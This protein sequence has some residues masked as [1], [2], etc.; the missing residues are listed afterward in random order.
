MSIESQ[1]DLDGLTRAGR[2]VALAIAAMRRN[3]RPGMSTKE[4]DDI[5]ADVFRQN[6]A[7]SAPQL[8]YGFPA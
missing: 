6:G 8:A 1:A 4:L 3:V 7:Q 2:V 5:G